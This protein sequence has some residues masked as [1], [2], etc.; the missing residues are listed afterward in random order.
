MKRLLIAVL[1]LL[2]VPLAIAAEIKHID[3]KEENNFITLNERDA[4]AFSYA[5]GDH[6]LMVRGIQDKGIDLTMFLNL[7]KEKSNEDDNLPYYFTLRENKDIANFDLDKNGQNDITVLVEEVNGKKVSVNI[8]KYNTISTT[9]ET[10]KETSNGLSIGSII[11]TAILA[12]IAVSLLLLA[13]KK[14]SK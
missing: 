12:L 8:K 4:L 1:I 5:N 2:A 3:I 11:W 13:L 10:V 14:K 9:E 6:R 7:Q